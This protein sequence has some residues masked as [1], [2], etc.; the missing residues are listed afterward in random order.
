MTTGLQDAANLGWKLAAQI[1][2]WAPEGLLDT[3]HGERH[4]VGERML[5][6]VRAQCVL[7]SP[8][9]H[10]EALRDLLAQL[11]TNP[12]TLRTVVHRLM[13][14]DIRY[15]PGAHP[16]VGDWAPDLK[17]DTGATLAGLMHSGRPLMLDLTADQRLR[18]TAAAWHDRV[19]TVTA[20]S[21]EPLA[22]LLV[23]PDGYVAW[24]HD[25]NDDGLV[26]A[27]ETWFGPA[28]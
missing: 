10:V 4:P 3:Y 2:G 6:F 23:R 5:S 8:G 27:L 20:G 18:D 7:L 15:A 26:H 17:L 14:L 1:R 28:A 13:G 21:D 12:A 9:P 11:L 16:L 22:G 25:D 19:D 24:A